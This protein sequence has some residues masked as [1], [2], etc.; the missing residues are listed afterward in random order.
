MTVN[1]PNP[2]FKVTVLVKG[3]YLNPVHFIFS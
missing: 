3:K 2:S 1:V